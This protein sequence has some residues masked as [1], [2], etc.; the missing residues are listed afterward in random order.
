M[1]GGVGSSERIVKT[2]IE[3]W[4]KKVSEQ[5][6]RHLPLLGLLKKKGRIED[7]CSGGQFRWAIRKKDHQLQGFPDMTPVQFKRV[8]TLENAFLPW[9]GYYLS[10]AITL[11]E[12]LEQGGPEAMIK[13]FA[14]RED[15]MREAA[16]RGL[17]EEMYVDG[18]SAA[19]VA[20]ESFHG[21]ESFMSVTGVVAGD[22]IVREGTGTHND[23][24]AGLSTA[25][26]AVGGS[27]Q[28][29]LYTPVVVNT[30]N[31]GNTWANFADDYVREARLAAT[32]GTG[33]DNQLDL[34]LLSR[35]SYSD[36]LGLMDA[37]ERIHIQRGTSTALTQIGFENHV[38]FDGVP[39]M[40]DDAIPATDAAGNTVRG[41]G[42]NTGR[43]KLKVLGPKGK[44]LW[45]SKVT[46]NDTYQAD[47]VFLYLLGNLCYESPRHFVKFADLA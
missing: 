7:G 41:Y 12:K 47:H 46:F 5:T 23:S 26:N 16:M 3:E 20:R 15:Q 34:V 11:R 10:D 42:F 28:P 14:N 29:Y 33:P 9:R 31:N 27:D 45:R 8:N 2:T 44:G 25:E 40:W 37:K 43:M 24:Y 4:S 21:I 18:N 36:F 22:L 17:A 32:Y 38:V 35:S 6:V 19:N 13:V 39:I 30:T 1:A